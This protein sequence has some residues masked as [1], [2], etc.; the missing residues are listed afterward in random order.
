VVV[1]F[2]RGPKPVRKEGKRLLPVKGNVL[3]GL[4]D[5]LS[6]RV[7]TL[8]G[9]RVHF[10]HHRPKFILGFEHLGGQCQFLDRLGGSASHAAVVVSE[11]VHVE[12]PQ[13]FAVGRDLVERRLTR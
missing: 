12:V 4:L 5:V 7:C 2:E 11:R 8:L 13:S 9:E 1:A 10:V 3:V 6:L